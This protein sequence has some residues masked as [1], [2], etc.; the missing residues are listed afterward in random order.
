VVSTLQQSCGIKRSSPGIITTVRPDV[1]P[2]PLAR[3]PLLSMASSTIGPSDDAKNCDISEVNSPRS[4]LQIA[5]KYT[6]ICETLPSPY[7]IRQD[8]VLV[9]GS[10]ARAN[11]YRMCQYSLGSD[12][13]KDAVI[14]ACGITWKIH[15]NILVRC[16][17]PVTDGLY[18]NGVP[19]PR[20]F[21]EMKE[22]KP[23]VT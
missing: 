6:D 21:L 9:P 4:L 17:S 12:L 13:D 14:K 20:S 15:S 3:T 16:S 2:S 19:Q 22:F 8:Y 1:A 23:I 5:F 18:M 11:K 10:I 7:Q